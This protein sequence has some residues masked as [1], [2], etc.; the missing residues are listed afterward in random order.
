MSDSEEWKFRPFRRVPK[1]IR[2]VF[3]GQLSIWDIDGDL[4][5]VESR[6]RPV[7]HTP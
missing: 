5:E 3:R 4:A 6:F 7:L 2:L 1:L